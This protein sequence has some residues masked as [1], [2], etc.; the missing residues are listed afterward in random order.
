MAVC[1]LTNAMYF[2]SMMSVPSVTAKPLATASNLQ[3]IVLQPL[4]KDSHTGQ[5]ACCHPSWKH[6]LAKVRD[7]HS[8]GYM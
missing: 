4:V 7:K 1:K 8:S 3:V 2:Q 5:V 6:L